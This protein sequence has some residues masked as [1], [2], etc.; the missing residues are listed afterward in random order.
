MVLIT[1]LSV[2]DALGFEPQLLSPL[3]LLL[4]VCHACLA[5]GIRTES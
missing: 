5:Y 2:S 1:A 4:D 3:R